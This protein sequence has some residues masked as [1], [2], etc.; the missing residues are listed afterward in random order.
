MLARANGD[1]QRSWSRRVPRI[2]HIRL[3]VLMSAS[4]NNNKRQKNGAG[5]DNAPSVG[6]SGLLCTKFVASGLALQHRTGRPPRLLPSRSGESLVRLSHIAR[7]TYFTGLQ[8]LLP[9]LEYQDAV[10]ESC[11]DDDDDDNHGM[12]ESGRANSCSCPKF[13]IVWGSLL[14]E[15]C[16]RRVRRAQATDA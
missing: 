3:V 1:C 14:N 4:T 5:L 10:G 11:L 2:V 8:L 7:D 12:D 15:E 9:V 16:H 6:V 13:R